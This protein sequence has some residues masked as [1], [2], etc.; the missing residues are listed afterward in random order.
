MLDA[1]QSPTPAG[2]F[3]TYDRSSTHDVFVVDDGTTVVGGGDLD[4]RRHGGFPVMR[5]P[6]AS[7]PSRFLTDSNG[8]RREFMKHTL[9]KQITNLLQDGLALHQLGRT[10]D[11][12]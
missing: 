6:L 2:D 4:E 12:F 1:Q 5:N 3:G 10:A 8:R 11:R 7:G 9:W